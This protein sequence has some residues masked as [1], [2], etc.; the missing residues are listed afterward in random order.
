MEFNRLEQKVVIINSPLNGEEDDKIIIL[1]PQVIFEAAQQLTVE[2]YGEYLYNNAKYISYLTDSE[3]N[4]I[5]SIAKLTK[6]HH[7]TSN[8][9]LLNTVF[10][11][12][13]G[14]Y[15]TENSNFKRVA[16]L[17]DSVTNIIYRGDGDTL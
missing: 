10:Y 11:Y 12:A 5:E 13:I 2:E 14:Y 6:K 17:I 3:K 15:R 1:V 8:S 16:F 4:F 7:Y 9:D